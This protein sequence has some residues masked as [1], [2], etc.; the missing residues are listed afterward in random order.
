MDEQE[1]K[2]I[3]M[4]LKEVDFLYKLSIDEIN[5]LISRFKKMVLKKGTVIIR[6]GGM[7]DSFFLIS[8]GRLA[9]W[10]KRRDGSKVLI[11][12]LSKGNYFGEISLLTGEKRTATVV[13]EQESILY[14][15]SKSD[16]RSILSQN[17]VI[18]EEIS[19][20]V[21]MRRDQLAREGE[22]LI[23][24]ESLLKKTLVFFNLE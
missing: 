9:V 23:E 10:M 8:E 16:F 15:L 18:A 7:G 13:T 6:Q 22:K 1:S 4:L 2:R 11:R 17:P 21:S 24:K 5:V 19:N 20:V 14:R 12:H 3:Y